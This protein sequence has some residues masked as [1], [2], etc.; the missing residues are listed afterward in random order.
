MSQFSLSKA[1]QYRGRAR[2][3]GR[4]AASAQSGTDRAR[5]LRMRDAC[6]M[7]ARNEDWLEGLPPIP[8]ANSSA[9]VR[10]A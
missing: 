10:S 5:L 4:F 3:C 7:L 8:P 2:A 9:L 1:Q 6:L